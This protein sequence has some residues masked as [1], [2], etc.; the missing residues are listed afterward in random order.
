M[1]LEINETTLVIITALVCATKVIV[2]ILKGR[3]DK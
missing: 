3:Q 1:L 2:T